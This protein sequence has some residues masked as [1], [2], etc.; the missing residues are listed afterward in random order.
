MSAP[1]AQGE[2][3]TQDADRDLSLRESVVGV[4]LVVSILVLGLAP[5]LVVG[6]YD[7]GDAINGQS[8]AP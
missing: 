4:A 6:L 2:P 5:G 1:V 7:F 3:V 8:V